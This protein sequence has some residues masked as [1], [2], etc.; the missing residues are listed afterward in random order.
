MNII[1][2]QNFN[3]DTNPGGTVNIETHPVPPSA[4]KVY[5]KPTLH[6]ISSIHT[7][8]KPTT[9]PIE[10]NIPASNTSVGS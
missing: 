8:G 10:G 7:E 5:S 2:E 9:T 1:E 4:K 6:V 3:G